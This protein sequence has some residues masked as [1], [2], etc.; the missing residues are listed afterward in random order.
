MALDVVVSLY[1]GQYIF[2]IVCDW[3]RFAYHYRFTGDW[4]RKWHRGWFF[5]PHFRIVTDWSSRRCG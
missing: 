4:F 3:W 5:A 2:G 1:R